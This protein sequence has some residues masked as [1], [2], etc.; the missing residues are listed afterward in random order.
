MES[1][2]HVVRVS[3]PRYLANLPVPASFGGIFRLSLGDWISLTPL[4]LLVVGTS[5]LSYQALF[6]TEG[7]ARRYY[8]GPAGADSSV[9]KSSKMPNKVNEKIDKDSPKVVH[10][11]EIEEIGE[12]KVFCRCW[13]SNK[14]PY[15]DGSHTKHNEE[16][17]DNVGPLIIKK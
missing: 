7:V 8:S 1:V 2:S 6:G 14:F 11:V 12:K 16:T 17:G 13:K 4:T 10:T 3:L 15:C 5:Y 9:K